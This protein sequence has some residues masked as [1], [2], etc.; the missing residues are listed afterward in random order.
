MRTVLAVFWLSMLS[1]CANPTKE[2]PVNPSSKALF[3]EDRAY[4]A[5]TS[6]RRECSAEA[7][8][9]VGS[10]RRR[11]SDSCEAGKNDEVDPAYEAGLQ[12]HDQ[13][14]KVIA[15]KQKLRQSQFDLNEIHHRTAEV[16][17]SLMSHQTS[18]HKRAALSRQLEALESDRRKRRDEFEALAVAYESARDQI[19]AR[20]R[21]NAAK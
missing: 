8:H 10:T 20:H 5:G 18:R 19:S 1:A 13:R 9:H 11:A 15:L 2:L 6:R 14:M 12:L 3:S 7:G 16:E 17:A 21:P 4:F